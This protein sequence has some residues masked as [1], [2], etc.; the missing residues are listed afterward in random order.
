MNKFGDTGIGIEETRD[1]R[2]AVISFTAP[3]VRE[4]YQ[5]YIADNQTATKDKAPS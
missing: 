5:Y 1:R 3:V 2:T 4:N